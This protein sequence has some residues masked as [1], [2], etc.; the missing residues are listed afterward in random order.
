MIFNEKG[1]IGVLCD[2]SVLLSVSG[3]IRVNATAS[4][5]YTGF[6]G[7]IG[8]DIL[9][10]FLKI[11]KPQPFTLNK[12]IKLVYYRR[13]KFLY[14][15]FKRLLNLKYSFCNKFYEYFRFTRVRST[16]KNSLYMTSNVFSLC[17]LFGRKFAA[18][19]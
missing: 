15:E 14:L 12:M 4:L 3:W 16:K 5:S 1:V 6:P 19:A 2:K 18:S 9:L 13:E 11:I 8:L 17:E 10:S 7:Q